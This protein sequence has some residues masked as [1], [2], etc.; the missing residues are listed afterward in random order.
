MVSMSEVVY[1]NVHRLLSSMSSEEAEELA[2]LLQD[3]VEYE[4]E[5]ASNPDYRG[6]EWH[7]VHGDPRTLNR[8]VTSKV[9]SITFSSNRYTLYRCTDLEAVERALEEYRSSFRPAEEAA[10][11]PD[12]LFGIIV[13]HDDKKDLIMRALACD[14]PVHF[15]LYGSPSSATGDTKV[16]VRDSHGVEAV[17]LN[18][19]YKRWMEGWRPE[20]LSVNRKTLRT[21]WK[22]I[23]DVMNHGYREVVRVTL[24]GG[25]EVKVT[26]DHSLFTLR[27]GEL[28]PIRCEDLRVGD[29]IPV[30]YK[31][32]YGSVMPDLNGVVLDERLGFATGIWLAD[33]TLFENRGKYVCELTNN[34]NDILNMFTEGIRRI[35][36]EYRPLKIKYRKHCVRTYRTRIFNH[37][38]PFVMDKYTEERGKGRSARNKRLPP[39][40][41]FAPKEFKR[42]LING[43]F[44]G[45]ARKREP[46]FTISSKELRDDMMMLLMDFGVP[47]T[48]RE[49]MGRGRYVGRKYYGLRIPESFKDKV[50]YDGGDVKHNDKI[51]R[52]PI[53]SEGIH[54]RR[55]TLGISRA[56][57]L[58]E[59]LQ[60]V[61][62]SDL[63]WDSIEKMEGAG[64]EEVYDLSVKDNENFVTSQGVLL[65]NSAKT[66]FLEELRRLPGS[67]YVLGGSLSKAGLY[68]VLF[69]ER[70]RYLLIDECIPDGVQVLTPYGLKCIG[71][72]TVGDLVYSMNLSSKQVEVKRVLYTSRRWFDGELLRFMNG[73][74]CD[75][76]VTP[77]HHMIYN[78]RPERPILIKRAG[79]L[80][81]YT[82][83][84]FL[85]PCNLPTTHKE[86][87]ELSI[88]SFYEP[89]D[90][91]YEFTSHLPNIKGLNCTASKEYLRKN[92][93]LQFN[94][95][96]FL[97]LLGWYVSEG[98]VFKSSKESRSLTCSIAVGMGE[99]RK[100][101]QALLDR[102]GIQYSNCP[103]ELRFRH[104][105]LC[106]ALIHY[107]GLHAR[108]KHLNPEVFSM[109]KEGLY[110]LF[111]ALLRGDGT[112]IYNGWIYYTS[113]ERLKDDITW[114]S[115]ILGY[116]ATS[117]FRGEEHGGWMVK[118]HPP[119]SEFATEIKVKRVPYK[120]WVN[121][122]T[123]EDNHN[124]FAGVDGKFV[125]V[126]NCDKVDDSSNLSCLLSL[127]QS[128]YISETKWGKMRE[129]SLKT[130]VFGACNSTS[131]IPAELMSRFALLRFRE[132]TAQ[133]FLE[134]V[135]KV[136]T[137]R[138]G[139]P[140]ELAVYIGRRVDGLLNSRDFRDAQRVAR[141]LREP[142]REE[143][144]RVVEL[145]RRQR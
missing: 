105:E 24:R 61:L 114:L 113:S 52:V 86:V 14:R 128:G 90:Y 45:D 92:T 27:N 96:D 74:T 68:E 81:N 17:P 144:D 48:I 129:A 13:G 71:E 28:V 132:Y 102:M 32:D 7:E 67:S 125:L 118:I 139:V 100:A 2:S 89:N 6:F 134:V 8:L 82:G 38:R 77:E 99:N 80:E 106:K 145:L 70:P 55:N 116:N 66:L 44:Q 88:E 78:S 1:R 76:P 46:H 5:R 124:F 37:F 65:H 135:E 138:E 56:K 58:L 73:F 31:T 60:R 50:G 20:A 127:M 122:I 119:R 142:T 53:P 94:C 47:T 18:V 9:L 23:L 43:F 123:V 11:I 143:V 87:D 16:I 40:V 34:S 19:L 97:E 69:N 22:P 79:E 25:R 101:I 115:M 104:R 51:I 84:R 39:W 12:D 41:F 72:L 109:P 137:V 108:G 107:G 85:K 54:I 62:D 49:V 33:G 117:Y 26:K 3:I 63:F 126:G 95:M 57:Q 21:E 64:V 103:N 120:G 121:D 75:I 93:G 112:K 133:E 141:L 42:G 15:L 35:D 130:W 36:P 98:S 131:G 111:R 30:V 91:V 4:R 136:L 110:R 140:S 59:H 83:I 10:A 29:S